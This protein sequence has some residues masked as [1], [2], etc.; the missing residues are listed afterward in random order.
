MCF[1][2]FRTHQAWKPSQ[3]RWFPCSMP[4]AHTKHGNHLNIGW[5]VFVFDHSS[6]IN[7]EDGKEDGKEFE[8]IVGM[9]GMP[10]ILFFLKIIFNSLC[11]TNT[12]SD[13]RAHPLVVGFVLFSIDTPISSSL[14]P[15]NARWR[16]FVTNHR[17]FSTS[18]PLSRLNTRRRGLFAHHQPSLPRNA[19]WMGFIAHHHPS[20]AQMQDGGPFYGHHHPPL[21]ERKLSTTTPFV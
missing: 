21:L 2:P 20:P 7:E 18:T 14:P 9:Q 16:A 10:T 11:R 6:A 8:D 1:V 12:T 15:S 4:S 3:H 13:E 5:C 19:G 17:L